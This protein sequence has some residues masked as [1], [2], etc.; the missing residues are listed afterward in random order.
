VVKPGHVVAGEPVSPRTAFLV[1]ER[2]VRYLRE[3]GSVASSRRL[4]KEVLALTVN[5]EAHAAQLLSTAFGRDPR[6]A[7]DGASW[8]LEPAAEEAAELPQE[9]APADPDIAFVLVEGAREAPRAPLKLTAIAAVRRRGDAIVAACGG[10]LSLW[11][12]GRALK[13]ELSALLEGAAVALHAP[14]GGR[15]A[16]EGW[17]GQPLDAPLPLARLAR[18]RAGPSSGPSVE[19]LAEALGL[20]VRIDDD[21]AQRVE[22]LP[23]CFDALRRPG[24]SWTALV[25][26]CRA[27]GVPLPW[28]RYAFTR[29]DLKRLPS[30]PG[31]YRF[32]DDGDNLIYVGKS[33][34]LR[35]RLAEW[36]REDAPRAARIRS[37]V[38]GVRRFEFKASGSELAAL[39]R[40]ASQI[41]RDK[42]ERNVQREV[43]RR[44][45]RDR[46]LSSILILEPAE[47]PWTLR[48]WLIRDG[49][50]LDTIPLG[51]RGGGLKR[52]A[53][54]LDASFF[55]SRGGP[56]STP[57]RDVD[58][59]LVARWLGENRDKAVAFDPTHLKSTEEV[60]ARLRWFLDR[61][62][63]VDPEGSPILP[64]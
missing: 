38:D 61:G 31:T 19:S 39:L 10:A 47:P 23:A 62:S 26:A 42:P 15:A 18:R 17:L 9:A 30:A 54:V 48:A 6:L 51:P 21:P 12:P 45:A 25:D 33:S 64:R 3:L 16:L 41:R 4:A 37:I 58:V 63:L 60:V 1:A 32:Y 43:H 49:R 28:H 52:I 7:Y 44:G 14:P 46:R 11:P 59:E 20:S 8:R 36:F 40:E 13:D 50:L 53:R 56:H 24:E 57:S 5:D 55:D 22:T 34:N 27:R 2:A 35:R 29:D